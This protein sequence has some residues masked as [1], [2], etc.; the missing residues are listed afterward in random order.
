MATITK[1]HKGMVLRHR[2]SGETLTVESVFRN[3]A[4]SFAGHPLAPF[5]ALVGPHGREFQPLASV[6]N[7]EHYEVIEPHA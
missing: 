5:A 6:E 2:E 1:A 3:P 7:D 4:T